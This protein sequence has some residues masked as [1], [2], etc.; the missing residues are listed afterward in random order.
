MP[1]SRGPAQWEL[2]PAGRSAGLGRDAEVHHEALLVGSPRRPRCGL[3]G[4]LELRALR[5]CPRARVAVVGCDGRRHG[6]HRLGHRVPSTAATPR[7]GDTHSESGRIR[8]RRSRPPRSKPLGMVPDSSQET[9]PLTGEVNRVGYP[10]RGAGRLTQASFRPPSGVRENLIESRPHTGG[11]VR[12][13]VSNGQRLPA[14][15]GTPR[16][17][18]DSDSPSPAVA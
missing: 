3:A 9:A 4:R 15:K 6:A 7:A 12:R 8:A 10:A 1:D 18:L 17:C 11:P 13:I 5:A 16:R 14:S 2:S